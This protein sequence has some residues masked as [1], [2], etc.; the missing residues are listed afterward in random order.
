MF[1]RC[2][3]RTKIAAATCY[4][5][6]VYDKRPD[7][8]GRTG[9]VP[10]FFTP[11]L[12][13]VDAAGKWNAIT[14]IANGARLTVRINGITTVDG[15]GPIVNAGAIALQWGEGDVRFRNVRVKPL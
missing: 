12:A 15:E 6:N 7:Q 11:P 3:E 5:I 4:E 2:S 8:S 9:A 1:I 10:G 14:I 13:H